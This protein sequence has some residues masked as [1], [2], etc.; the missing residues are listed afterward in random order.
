MN[1]RH[2]TNYADLQKLGGRKMATPSL[3]LRA[4]FAG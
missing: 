3:I 4:A 2:K 1:D